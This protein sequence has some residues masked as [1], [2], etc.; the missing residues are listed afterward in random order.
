MET[1]EKEPELDKV[2]E[3]A[4]DRLAS[5][6]EAEK[7]SEETKEEPKDASS[8]KSSTEKEKTEGNKEESESKEDNRT[9]NDIQILE[10][11][12]KDL[13]EEEKIR[14][15]DL[16]KAQEEA[17]TPEEKEKA[18]KEKTQKRIDELI[19]EL[20]AEK[21][22]RETDNS[23][24]K[25]LEEKIEALTGNLEKSGSIESEADRISKSEEEV[26]AKMIEEDSNLP[27][28]K[29]REMSKEEYEEFLLEDYAGATSWDIRRQIRRDRDREAKEKANQ[30]QSD[31][32]KA[33]KAFF[34]EFPKCNTEARGNELMAQGKSM[35]EAM[36][37]IM[38]ENPDFKRMMDIIKTD[39]K[40]TKDPN[41]LLA[42]MRKSPEQKKSSFTQEELEKKIEDAVMKERNRINSVDVGI[43]SSDSGFVPPASNDPMY[44]QGLKLF[45]QAGKRKG[46][47]WTEKDYKE[48]LIY[49]ETQR[50]AAKD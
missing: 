44:N 42:E 46:K 11:D 5:M 6:Q 35:N 14:K 19:G 16:V 1:I 22:G 13:S 12:E 25:A 17:K 7:K 18:W 26:Y 36:D 27:R 40:Y 29:R 48:T 3:L 2:S 31:R 24:I 33:A 21:A 43:T 47:D 50:K 15:V 45:I 23:Q 38:G 30:D 34:D 37:I 10:S 39:P 28:N 4:K 8:E 49:G 9:K 32:D 20:K 41:L